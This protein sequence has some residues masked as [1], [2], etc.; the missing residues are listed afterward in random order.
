MRRKLVL[1]GTN[2]KD[3]KIL[4]ALELLEKENVVNI[5]T[6][7][8]NVAT[9]EFYKAM[10]EKWKDDVEVEFPASFHKIERKLSVSDSLLPDEIKVERTDLI[11]R[12]QAEWHF[13]VLSSKLYGLYKS[14]LEELKE[15]IEG[16]GAYDN[17]LWTDLRDFWAKVQGQVNDKNLFREHGAALREKTNHLFDKLKELKKSLEDEFEVQ[18][19]KYVDDF[20]S[21]LAE[22]EGK[23]DRGLGLS[24]LFEDLKK[25]QAKIKNFKFTKDDRNEL[26]NKIDET[27]KKLKE[28]RGNEVHQFTNNNLSRLEAR[29]NGLIGA[30]QKMQKSIDFDQ[31]DLDFQVKKVADSDGQLESQL[32]AAKIRMIEERLKS[33]HEKLD[34]MN[35][36]KSELESKM[37][38][39]KKRAV[40]VEKFEK[41][42]EAKVAVKQ[43]IADGIA[44]QSKEL[45]K[46][47]DKL[48]KAATELVKPKKSQSIIEKL[49]ESVEQLVEDVVDTAKAVAEVAGD[50][51]EDLMDKAEDMA[52]KAGE[53]L[54]DIKA[55][56]EVLADQAEE[57]FEDVVDKASDVV[58]DLKSKVEEK[59][60]DDQDEVKTTQ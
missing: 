7:P 38:K 19:K 20:K 11:T 50:K 16:L 58:D 24:P 3:A 2:E 28:K 40:K 55:Q 33:K 48:E 39:E 12:A 6:F 21:E 54:E 18:S 23:V 10:S 51:L 53:K 60:D 17:N 13:V 1:W 34:D 4:V 47:S 56:A 15:K 26:W 41:I 36:T 44:E 9:E 43:K 27:F 31:K 25:V 8:E 45:D 46:I 14:E 37:E 59:L 30:I 35:L 29:Y 5:Y 42:E 52:E 32:R 22:I 49:T 57:K